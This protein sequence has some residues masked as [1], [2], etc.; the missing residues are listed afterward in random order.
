MWDA[1]TRHSEEGEDDH[2]ASS[3]SQ[4]IVTEHLE[5]GVEGVRCL[6]QTREGQVCAP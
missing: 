2:L 1:R 5:Q 6:D 4:V 3:L